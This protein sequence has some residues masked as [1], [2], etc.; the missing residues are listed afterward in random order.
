[1]ARKSM[2][3]NA[4]RKR[5]PRR[6]T[7]RRQILSGDG[8][9]LAKHWGMLVNPC[10]ATL[11]ESA[12]R[13]AAGIPSR[14][15]RTQTISVD[16]AASFT[17]IANPAALSYFQTAVLSSATPIVPVYASP[18]AGNTFVTANSF[19]FRIIGFCLSVEYVG[20]EL[21]RSGK[22]YTGVLPAQTITG[23]VATTADAIKSILT[24]SCRTPDAELESLWFPGVGNE[25]YSSGLVAEEVYGNGHNSLV[26]IAENMPD[27]IQ[28]Q[29]RETVI[30]EWQPRTGQGFTASSPAGGSNPVSAYEKLHRAAHAE[31]AF[32]GFRQGMA[33]RASQYA[34]SVGS[35]FVDLA[36]GALGTVGRA[37]MRRMAPVAPLLLGL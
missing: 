27:G 6:N 28:I 22:L 37:A 4:P 5:Q 11:G 20:S 26:F 34:H 2:A 29:I 13:G 36:A 15:T 8:S 21:N 24:S 32:G 17:Y 31:G 14:F 12:Y 25:E 19:A 18:M 10:E 1:M 30:V 16:G 23:G 3:K 35:G 9:V 7:R 33:T